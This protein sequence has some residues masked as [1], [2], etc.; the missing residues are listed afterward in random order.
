MFLSCHVIGFETHFDYMDGL[1]LQVIGCKLWRL[2]RTRSIMFPIADTVFRV[3]HTSMED[4]QHIELHPGSLLYIPRGYAHEA[5]MNCSSQHIITSSSGTVSSA[6]DK[7]VPVSLHITFGLEVGADSTMEVFLHHLVNKLQISDDMND[8]M[9]CTQTNQ[10]DHEQTG[11]NSD[12]NTSCSTKNDTTPFIP[13]TAHTIK[14]LGTKEYEGHSL[15]LDGLDTRDWLHLLI[16]VAACMDDGIP[17]RKAIATTTFIAKTFGYPLLT[18]QLSEVKA[19]LTSVTSLLWT[20]SIND[21][22]IHGM[23]RIMEPHIHEEAIGPT[24]TTYVKEFLSSHALK[25]AT[26]VLTSSHIGHI[27]QLSDLQI[28]HQLQEV[29]MRL[30]TIIND[31]ENDIICQAWSHMIEILEKRR[32][33]RMM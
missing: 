7:K 24:K 1:V 32:E 11:V 28:S 15:Q 33:E 20:P 17:L 5:A 13:S 14:L 30:I 31:D 6:N 4:A 29:W 8:A 3:N 26:K 25:A 2:A 16:H 9:T 27:W 10:N 23:L 22:V 21:H 12:N 18:D 19:Y